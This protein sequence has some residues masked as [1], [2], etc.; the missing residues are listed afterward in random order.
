MADRRGGFAF[1]PVLAVVIR[2][3]LDFSDAKL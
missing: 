2:I 3:G 1:A